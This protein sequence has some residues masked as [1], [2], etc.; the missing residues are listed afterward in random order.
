MAV[1]DYIP[2]NEGVLIPHKSPTPPPFTGGE[3]GDRRGGEAGHGEQAAQETPDP[4][5]L[6]Q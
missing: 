1:A 5:A 3:G 6:C 2:R 4:N